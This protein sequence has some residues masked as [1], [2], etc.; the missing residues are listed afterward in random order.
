MKKLLLMIMLVAGISVRANAQTKV[1]K[2]PEQKAEHITKILEKKLAL[3]AAQTVK[4]KA[5][6]FKR[7]TQMDSLKAT[8]T[9]ADRKTGRQSRK[10]I[11]LAADQDLKNVLTESQKKTYTELKASM[12][13][14]M[15]G[16]RHAPKTTEG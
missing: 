12:K 10:A 1:K 9:T 6:V 15:K 8:R 13:E 5:I 11:L 14:K 3:N 7:A 16:K 2:T 4:V